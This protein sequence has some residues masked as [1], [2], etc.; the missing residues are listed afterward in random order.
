MTTQNTSTWNQLALRH[1]IARILTTTTLAV[2]LLSG[3]AGSRFSERAP[4]WADTL[5]ASPTDVTS[6]TS[7]KDAATAI[8][9]PA[10]APQTAADP[11]FVRPGTGKLVNITRPPSI[12]D[13]RAQP[14]GNV[15]LNFQQ[16]NLPEVVKVILGDM[17][18][19]N[20]IIDPSVQGVVSMQ[21]TKPIRQEDLI[22]TLEML[23]RMNNAALVVDKGMYHIVPSAKALVE[24][25]A[26]QLGDSARALP[27]GF[28]VKVIPLNYIAAEEIAQILEPFI[29]DG[30]QILRVDSGR[31][32]LIIAAAS[33]QMERLLDIIDVFDVDR[34]KGMS[35]GLFTPDFVDAK[36]LADELKKLLSDPTYG[37]MPGL[38][39]FIVV[40]HLNGLIVVTPKPDQLSVIRDWIARLDRSSGDAS[41]RLFVYRVQNGKATE[42]AETLDKLFN[43]E[44]NKTKGQAA[45]VAPGLR[46]VTIGDKPEEQ[47]TAT[48]ASSNKPAKPSTT[49]SVENKTE[50]LKIDRHSDVQIIADEANNALLILAKGSEYRQILSALKQLD[51]NPMQVLIEVTIAEVSLTDD[52]KFGVEWFFRNHF[53]SK[54]GVGTLDLG[55]NGINVLSPGFSYALQTPG[56]TVEAVLNA[57]ATESNLRVIQS[58]SLLVLNNEEATIQVGDEVPVTTQEQ[59]ATTTTSNILNSF[60]YRKTGI[61]LKVKPRINAGG[62][63]IMEVEQ[64]ASQVPKTDIGSNTPRIKQR[65]INSTVAVNSGDTIILGGLIQ[66]SRDRTEA[67]VPILHKLPVIGSLFGSKSDNQGRTE[68]I[69]LITPRAVKNSTAALQVTEAFRRRL[70][71]LIPDRPPTATGMIGR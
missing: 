59:Q 17:V 11:D 20:Y 5:R 71:K 67:G 48:D 66:D 54:N 34:M 18:G 47:S 10:P 27:A 26:P 62:M 31:N 25:Q 29:A 36:T 43:S 60:E 39:R 51:V 70:Q 65:K 30:N 44:S 9:P 38:V 46:K 22:P 68:L 52:L 35:V 32:L 49:A 57:L 21:T 42:L 15:K 13:A 16:A 61:L 1:G 7:K 24:T 6:N 2:L 23:L 69:I 4:V 56:G 37:L 40:D 64:E 55:S 33:G 58:P 63:V 28:S 45:E 19:V 8:P 53:S 41:Q 50:G 14:S 12:A 3:C